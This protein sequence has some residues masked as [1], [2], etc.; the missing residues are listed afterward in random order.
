MASV[1]AEGDGDADGLRGSGSETIKA[2][3]L[4][5]LAKHRLAAAVWPQRDDGGDT[6]MGYVGRSYER[7][8]PTYAMLG[9]GQWPT[10]ATDTE[11]ACFVHNEYYGAAH[12]Q[13][14]HLRNPF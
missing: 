3:K 10:R 14:H 13:E 2:I 7:V 11:L 8:Q 6:A 12:L 1:V 5:G 4:Q 9:L